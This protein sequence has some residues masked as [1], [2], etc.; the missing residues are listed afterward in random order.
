[1]SYIRSLSNPEK[2]YIWGDMNDTL[3]ISIS[4]Y[5][6]MTMP[7][8]VFNMLIKLYVKDH[9]SIE[10]YSFNGGKL[11]Y[12]HVGPFKDT[13]MGKIG[14]FKWVL[15]Y[16]KQCLEMWDSTWSLIVL[17]NM[18]RMCTKKQV[19]DFVQLHLCKR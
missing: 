14:E 18:S 12:K 4:A 6:E 8:S 2:L 11:V 17:Q 15:T 13:P 3:H 16:K 9:G 5:H 7:T 19:S 10:N 1:M